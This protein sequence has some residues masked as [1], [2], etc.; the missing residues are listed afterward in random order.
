M[1]DR[2]KQPFC[3]FARMAGFFYLAYILVFIVSNTLQNRLIDWSDPGLTARSI[4]AAPGLFRLGVALELVASLLFLLTAWA[5]FAVFER[6]DRS[7]ALLF[8]VLNAVG[9]AIESA[10]ALLH[11]AALTVC[12]SAEYMK[13]FSDDQWHTFMQLWLKVSAAGNMA[14]V[15]FYGA[16]LFPLGYLVMRSRLLPRIL[17][18]L[19]LLDG[20]SLVLCFLQVWLWP[21]HERWT[22]PLFPIMFVAE[23][24]LG[25]WLVIRG[26]NEPEQHLV[27]A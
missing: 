18:L 12:Q 15:L 25:L 4:A 14:T 16:W 13:G 19:L 2:S 20:A 8:L 17:G 11:Y 26:V 6:V 3:T 5:L 7:L 23:F 22:Y 10:F 27:A 21:G 1:H 9:V 24:G